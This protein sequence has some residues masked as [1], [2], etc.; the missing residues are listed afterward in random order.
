MMRALAI[1]DIHGC[2]L[3]FRHLVEDVVV[4]SKDDSLFLLGDYID[5]GPRSA[6]LV[7]YIIGL[8]QSGFNVTCLMGNHERMLLDAML[9]RGYLTNWLINSGDD[10]LSSYEA[11]YGAGNAYFGAIPHHHIAFYNSLKLYAL[12]DDFV[13]VHGFVDVDSPNPL[14]NEQAILWAR[15]KPIPHNC[16][17][18]KTVIHGHTPRSIEQIRADIG[19]AATRYIGIDAGCVY[20]GLHAGAGNLCCLNLSAMELYSV[21]KMD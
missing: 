11:L 5:R 19:S 20:A 6:E 3:T 21:P 15:P 17:T 12:V 18:G 7:E 9:S 4:L 8:S 2:Y 1:S 13:L 16:L 14:G 10:T